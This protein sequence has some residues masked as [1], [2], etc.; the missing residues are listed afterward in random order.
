[1]LVCLVM[2]LVGMVTAAQVVAE[3][4]R[5]GDIAAAIPDLVVLEDGE[6]AAFEPEITPEFYIVY[7]TASW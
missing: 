6:L 7:H 2:G 4:S 3:E 1:M 5:A